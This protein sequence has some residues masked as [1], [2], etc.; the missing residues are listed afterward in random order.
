L[1]SDLRKFLSTPGENYEFREKY[2]FLATHMRT[3]IT[4]RD[5]H[6]VNWKRKMNGKLKRI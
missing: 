6:G 1:N 4:F 5:S 2:E 3:E